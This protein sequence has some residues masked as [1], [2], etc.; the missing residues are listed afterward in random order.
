MPAGI[1]AQDT[2]EI[3]VIRGGKTSVAVGEQ[4]QFFAQRLGGAAYAPGLAVWRSLNEEVLAVDQNGNGKGLKPGSATIMAT[5]G[6]STSTLDLT[7]V[8]TTSSVVTSQLPAQP[9]IVQGLAIQGNR[10]LAIEG[11]ASLSATINGSPAANVSWLSADPTTVA[12]DASG[13][14]KGLKPGKAIIIASVGELSDFVAI[15]VTGQQMQASAFSVGNP[16]DVSIPEPTSTPALPP[17]SISP[18]AITPE[19]TPAATLPLP[20]QRPVLQWPPIE[21][22]TQPV[23]MQTRAPDEALRSVTPNEQTNKQYGQEQNMQAL[24]ALLNV[25]GT[26]AQQTQGGQPISAGLPNQP[27]QSQNPGV[28]S[29]MNMFN[30]FLNPQKGGNQPQGI[31]NIQGSNTGQ[32]TQQL[33]G[34]LGMFKNLKNNSSSQKPQAVQGL[35][36]PNQTNQTNQVAQQLMSLLGNYSN[37]Q[38][39]PAGQAS[40]QAAPGQAQSAQFLQTFMSL[41]NNIQQTQNN[42]SNQAQTG[43][44]QP[45]YPNPQ[46]SFPPG[47]QPQPVQSPIPNTPYAPQQNTM[48]QPMP[49]DRTA[50]PSDQVATLLSA[51]AA[52]MP[53]PKNLVNA[54]TVYISYQQNYDRVISDFPKKLREWG[55]WTIVNSPDQADILLYLSQGRLSVFSNEIVVQVYDRSQQNIATVS[56]ERRLSGTGGVLVNRLKKEIAKQENPN[57]K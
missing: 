57:K 33:T 32:I 19:S 47:G 21:S 10:T 1:Q 44:Q 55:R 43:F 40:W 39:N 24:Q 30:Y 9:S 5:V 36:M 8:A 6:R 28:N 34:L 26:A 31:P 27:P 46:A 2:S 45:N 53:V 54:K 18:L 41:M 17:A 14:A 22:L 7:V 35:A 25:L 50:A 29:Y 13:K 15:E 56:C 48:Q 23:P 37:A 38:Q 16:M 51:L 42:S 49:S 52:S 4:V 12:V 11:Q 3:V 20:E